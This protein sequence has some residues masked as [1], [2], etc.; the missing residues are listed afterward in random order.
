V[1]RFPLGN[2]GVNYSVTVTATTAVIH[3]DSL[4]ERKKA[5]TRMALHEAALHLAVER[6]YAD[7]TV[8]AIADAA[9]VS[10]R[11]FS[12]YFANKEDAVLYGDRRRSAELV[13]NLSR[14]PASESPWEA[15]RASALQLYRSEP[16]PDPDWLAQLRLLRQHPALLTQQAGFL[17]RLEQDLADQLTRRADGPDPLTALIMSSCFLAAIRSAINYWLAHPSR[18]PL[19]DIVRD[20]LDRVTHITAS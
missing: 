3:P 17:T 1:Q 12:N 7:L 14:R 13:E 5:A 20:A 15:L 11:T 8:E 2:K 16:R 6:G 10:R 19:A 18:L 9:D 4:R